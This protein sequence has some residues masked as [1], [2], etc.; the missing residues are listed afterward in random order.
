MDIRKE[1]EKVVGNNKGVEQPIIVRCAIWTGLMHH[2]NNTVTTCPGYEKDKRVV[3]VVPKDRFQ[4]FLSNKW[5]P[6]SRKGVIR[7]LQYAMG[8][9]RDEEQIAE[10]K[11][12]VGSLEYQDYDPADIDPAVGAT[13][14]RDGS[15][16]Y[17][18]ELAFFHLEVTAAELAPNEGVGLDKAAPGGIVDPAFCEVD[19]LMSAGKLVSSN[20]RLVQKSTVDPSSQVRVPRGAGEKIY[21]YRRRI[22]LEVDGKNDGTGYRIKRGMHDLNSFYSA[23]CA[24]QDPEIQLDGDVW[25]E[26]VRSSLSRGLYEVWTDDL[27]MG[28]MLRISRDQVQEAAAR[29]TRYTAAAEQRYAT[30]RDHPAGADIASTAI[31][32][33]KTYIEDWFGDP[34][35]YVGLMQ[36]MMQLA[37]GLDDNGSSNSYEKLYY[38]AG[39]TDY[40]QIYNKYEGVEI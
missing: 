38:D 7:S 36:L 23:R 39:V 32:P 20:A 13:I 19:C 29:Y 27:R 16:N 8:V 30:E 1:L 28:P 11:T 37:S 33:V 25:V 15:G 40:D 9:P 2:P 12:R 21:D 10:A 4:A 34:N 3:W 31:S 18:N 17:W 6:E 5:K 26:G 22:R 14:P 24:V 35:F